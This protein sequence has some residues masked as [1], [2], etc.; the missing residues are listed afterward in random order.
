M[1]QPPAFITF[2]DLARRLGRSQGFVRKHMG[3]MIANGFPE[4]HPIMGGYPVAGVEAWIESQSQARGNGVTVEGP[5]QGVNH[6][7]L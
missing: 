7:A 6:D 3:R 4:R 1:T 2:K 5:K